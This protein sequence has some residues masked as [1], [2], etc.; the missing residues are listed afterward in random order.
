[1]TPLTDA[2]PNLPAWSKTAKHALTPTVRSV[3]S[4]NASSLFP[5]PPSVVHLPRLVLTP[6]WSLWEMTVFVLLASL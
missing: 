4:A 3:L 6:L 2:T 1:M 5:T